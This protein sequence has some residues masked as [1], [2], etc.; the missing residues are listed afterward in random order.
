MQSSKFQAFVKYLLNICFARTQTKKSDLP[1]VQKSRSDFF[2]Q[3]FVKYFLNFWFAWTLYW[4]IDQCDWS[5]RRISSV[6]SKF[7]RLQ[8]VVSYVLCRCSNNSYGSVW[9]LSFFLIL[10]AARLVSRIHAKSNFCIHSE[11]TKSVVP[12]SF[13]LK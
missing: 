4:C 12:Y 8:S 1:K 6:K 13:R 10:K 2:G 9:N 7:V 11:E 3:I 5:L